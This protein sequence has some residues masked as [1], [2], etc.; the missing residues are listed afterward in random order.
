MDAYETIK[1]YYRD[2]FPRTTLQEFIIGSDLNNMNN[3]G[4][5]YSGNHLH[6]QHHTHMQHINMGRKT[7]AGGI[8]D[9]I[10]ETICGVNNPPTVVEDTSGESEPLLTSA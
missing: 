3:G 6:P 1:L 5:Q 2:G 4:S 7:S 10:V 8:L 9:T